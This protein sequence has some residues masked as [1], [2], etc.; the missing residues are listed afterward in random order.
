MAIHQI[1]SCN[2]HC[3]K[4]H[5]RVKL[6]KTIAN[7]CIADTTDF[8]SHTMAGQLATAIEV[9]LRL[10]KPLALFSV[11]LDCVNTLQCPLPLSS[12]MA[13]EGCCAATRC[14]SLVVTD[15]SLYICLHVPR[16]CLIEQSG[17]WTACLQPKQTWLVLT[18]TSGFLLGS[19]CSPECGTV[20]FLSYLKVASQNQQLCSSCCLLSNSRSVFW[21]LQCGG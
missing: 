7:I 10:G 15:V 13:T 16:L 11:R 17:N 2:I 3:Q 20:L 18:T 5:C 12:V 8:Y 19:I 21:L 1:P 9:A 14:L 4:Y 6:K